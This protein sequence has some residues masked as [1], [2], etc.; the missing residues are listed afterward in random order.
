AGAPREPRR[1]VQGGEAGGGPWGRSLYRACVRA[2]WAGREA[3][4][5]RRGGPRA[6]GRGSPRRVGG[7]G[8]RSRLAGRAGVAEGLGSWHT[9]PVPCRNYT[10][11]PDAPLRG[12]ASEEAF[13]WSPGRE[14]NTQAVGEAQPT[15]LVKG[16]R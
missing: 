13:S 8:A 10:Q 3:V 5:W 2:S 7:G 15:T 6:C 4:P 12:V 9:G 11:Q 14:S 1:S 16:E